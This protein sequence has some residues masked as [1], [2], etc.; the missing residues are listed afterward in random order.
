[1]L[2]TT[3]GLYRD[4]GIAQASCILDSILTAKLYLLCLV[5]DFYILFCQLV[6]N[7]GEREE[8]N[9]YFCHIPGEFSLITLGIL[10]VI[11]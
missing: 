10:K 9:T 5:L 3:L 6:V 4:L 7:F 11:Q 1:M 8:G 2:T